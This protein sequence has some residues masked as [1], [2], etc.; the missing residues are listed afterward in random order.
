[1]TITEVEK[2]A[3]YLFYCREN[4]FN[5][6]R[7]A[8]QNSKN[9]LT[10]K[11]LIDIANLY[12]QNDRQDEFAG[13]L[14]EGQYFVQLWTAHLII[15]FGKPNKELKKRCLE[16][17]EKYSESTLSPE[18]AIQEKNWLKNYLTEFPLDL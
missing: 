12:F 9:K 1:M 15:E 17:I 7:P 8:D 5:N 2:N 3:S 10:F 18:V 6:I 13:Y 14:M 4:Y 11:K 16:E